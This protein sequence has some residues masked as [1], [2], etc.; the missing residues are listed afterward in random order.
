LSFSH[1]ENQSFSRP[2]RLK[3]KDALNA[4]F[5][6]GKKA[7]AWPIVLHYLDLGLPQPVPC[8]ATVS[9]S[10]RRF[11][12]AVDRNRIK[13]LIREAW[14]LEKTP[15]EKSLVEQGK[16]RA[17]VFIFVGN[18]IP[19]FDKIRS[20]VQDALKKMNRQTNLSTNDEVVS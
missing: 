1:Q 6:K 7:Q 2:Y 8:Q 20:C 19:A 16:Q 17:I 12:K 18:E 3:S 9:V 5:T 10:K 14:R 15:L 13:R 4:V 11:K